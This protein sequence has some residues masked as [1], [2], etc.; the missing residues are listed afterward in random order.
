MA[1]PMIFSVL[2]PIESWKIYKGV[3]AHYGNYNHIGDVIAGAGE[4]DIVVIGTS[5]DQTCI[6]TPLLAE[7]MSAPK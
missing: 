3:P 5:D 2:W 7:A 4:Y 1:A 6:D